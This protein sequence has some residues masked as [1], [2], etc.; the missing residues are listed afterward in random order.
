[1]TSRSE[2]NQ[3][4][5]RCAMAEEDLVTDPVD[6]IKS[7]RWGLSQGHMNVAPECQGL[8]SPRQMHVC[9]PGG[10]NYAPPA[11]SERVGHAGTAYDMGTSTPSPSMSL[12][13]PQ[14]LLPMPWMPQ[15]LV[16]MATA[17]SQ[18]SP[19]HFD[20]PRAS[21]IFQGSPQDLAVDQ[22]AFQ[23]QIFPLPP[24]Y[25]PNMDCRQGAFMK[26]YHMG[27]HPGM[28]GV[29]MKELRGLRI[30]I[31]ITIE[32]GEHKGVSTCSFIQKALR[33]RS[34]SVLSVIKV[35]KGML[36]EAGL[37]IPF[38]GGL[39]SYSVFLMVCAAHDSYVVDTAPLIQRSHRP[40]NQK[41]KRVSHPKRSNMTRDNFMDSSAVTAAPSGELFSDDNHGMDG[42]KSGSDGTPS[43]P[44]DLASTATVAGGTLGTQHSSASLTEV[45]KYCATGTAR[46]KVQSDSLE[47]KPSKSVAA[48]DPVHVTEGQLLLHF[49]QFFTKRFDCTSHGVDAIGLQSKSNVLIELSQEQLATLGSSCWIS[50]PLDTSKNVARPSFMWRQIQSM[51]AETLKELDCD[52]TRHHSHRARNTAA[53]S[54]SP[55]LAGNAS[56]SGGG[57]ACRTETNS[58]FVLERTLQASQL[59]LRHSYDELSQ[60][61]DGMIYP[62][63]PPRVSQGHVRDQKYN[64]HQYGHMPFN[65]SQRGHTSTP[66]LD[67]AFSYDSFDSTQKI[68]SQFGYAARS[69]GIDSPRRGGQYGSAY[70]NGGGGGGGGGSGFQPRNRQM[71]MPDSPSRSTPNMSAFTPRSVS[72]SPSSAHHSHMPNPSHNHN[73]NPKPNA[74]M[75]PRRQSPSSPSCGN[76]KAHGQS[77]G[78]VQ[79]QGHMN[80]QGYSPHSHMPSHGFGHAVSPTYGG[81]HGY[82]K[83]VRGGGGGRSRG[84]GIGYQH[85]GVQTSA[86]NPKNVNGS[87]HAHTQTFHG[88]NHGGNANG[89]FQE[90][91]PVESYP[92]LNDAYSYGD[93][94]KGSMRGDFSQYASASQTQG[95]YAGNGQGHQGVYPR[96]G[97]SHSAD[98]VTLTLPTRVVT[99]QTVN[100]SAGAGKGSFQGRRNDRERCDKRMVE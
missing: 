73:N 41:W 34:P 77:H 7:G 81:E 47:H 78:H 60:A 36:Q 6:P 69:P 76:G 62:P 63:R 91:V 42:G 59:M 82:T 21:R 28:L 99:K 15:S 10:M 89:N 45:A 50:D 24:N 70:G 17:C 20:D 71:S 84:H 97:L 26:A 31:D 5:E 100:V 98:E 30:P 57:R 83:G 23:H 87:R 33:S 12:Y 2:D 74:R 38:S 39:S 68:G 29:S 75:H 51:F 88:G 14:P 3:S 16:H 37:N 55:S 67:R 27:L 79:G 18:T 85:V 65:F 8:P 58:K 4:V 49:L 11:S 46:P 96:A 40:L 22:H 13:G 35:V 1:M 19:L 56:T 92:N 72:A 66:N 9:I 64:Q 32:G 25:Q 95:Q 93:D 52:L 86:Y 80:V 44:S 53:A 61:G 48:T 43:P 90:W 54:S 94:G